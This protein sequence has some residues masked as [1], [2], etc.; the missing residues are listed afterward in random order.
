MKQKKK[1]IWFVPV[2]A[3]LA[4]LFLLK[5]VFLIGYVP[6]ASMEPTIRQG[7]YI[8]GLRVYGELNQG[9]I[10]IFHHE[11]RLL[12]KRIAA[13]GG[14][15]VRQGETTLCVPEG[16]FYVLG[17]NTEDSKDSRHWGDPFVPKE[18]IEGR[19]VFYSCC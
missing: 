5:S 8:I 3:T 11:G 19:I 14:E 1:S 9:D 17:D 7:S 18:Y 12:V 2:A 16:E 13:V 10:I 15:F 6:T 4:T